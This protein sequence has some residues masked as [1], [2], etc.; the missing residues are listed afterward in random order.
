MVLLDPALPGDH[1]V[2]SLIPKDQRF[3][4]DFSETTERLDDPATSKEAEALTADAPSIP[5]TLLATEVLEL[6]RSLPVGEITSFVRR[7]QRR[8]V[9]RFDPGRL[10]VLDAPHSM[11]GAIPDRI[12]AEV[13]RVV[14]L[15][16]A[17]R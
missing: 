12:A 2:G 13:D 9:A 17:T 11:E 1:R 10:L 6:D 3:V 7:L 14:E 8:V 15:S 4:I 5:V 16:A